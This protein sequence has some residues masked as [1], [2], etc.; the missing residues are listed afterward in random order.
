MIIFLLRLAR[1]ALITP[2]CTHL[3]IAATFS[4]LMVERILLSI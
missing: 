4:L 2:S 3:A 1:F